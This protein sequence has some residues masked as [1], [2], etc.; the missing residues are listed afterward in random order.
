MKR[1]VSNK[2]LLHPESPAAPATGAQQENPEQQQQQGGKQGLTRKASVASVITPAVQE[3]TKQALAARTR[4]ITSRSR[5]SALPDTAAEQAQ[6]HAAATAAVAAAAAGP[7]QGRPKRSTSI[8]PQGYRETSSADEQQGTDTLPAAAARL[9]KS[10]PATAAGDDTDAAI[11]V[12]DSEDDFMPL[13]ANTRRRRQSQRPTPAATAA[14]TAEEEDKEVDADVVTSDEVEVVKEVQSPAAAAAAGGKAKRGRPAATAAEGPA[15]K[16]PRGRA[17]KAAAA[18]DAAADGFPSFIPADDFSGGVME[19]YTFQDR[20]TQGLGYYRTPAAAAAADGDALEGSV[21]PPSIGGR[22][23]G[24]GRGGGRGRGRGRKSST[25][26]AAAAVDGDVDADTAAAAA[27]AVAAAEEAAA[28][29]GDDSDGGVWGPFDDEQQG[30]ELDLEAVQGSADV[31]EPSGE[32]LLPLLPF[33]KQFLA[34]GIKQ[35]R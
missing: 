1:A 9:K 23:K 26:A 19:G 33:Q 24:R 4:S 25:A 29:A 14:A 3:E 15:A 35:V 7:A 8:A 30:D 32:V 2:Q 21:E 28:A 20:G 27:A 18:G 16:K 22:G 5:S 10:L 6:E 11:C 17:K 13:T 34:W 12:S 31:A